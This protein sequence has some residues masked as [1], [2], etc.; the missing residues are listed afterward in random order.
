MAQPLE[1]REILV[2][3][4]RSQHLAKLAKFFALGVACECALFDQSLDN[5]VLANRNEPIESVSR[6]MM[7]NL[8]SWRSVMPIDHGDAYIVRAS[9]VKALRESGSR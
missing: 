4:D 8:P 6:G 1:Q 3:I 9:A 2:V 5:V 7:L